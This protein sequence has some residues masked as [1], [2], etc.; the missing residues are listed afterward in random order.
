MKGTSV[1]IVGVGKTMQKHLLR[2]LL[3]EIDILSQDFAMSQAIFVIDS[4]SLDMQDMFREWA[5]KSPHN[6]TILTVVAPL[7]EKE[8]LFVNSGSALLPREGRIA[9]ARNIVLQEYQKGP[10]TEYIIQVDL[11]IVGWDLGGVRDSFGRSA[12]WDVACAHG[13]ILFGIYRD[14]YALRAPGINTNHHLSGLDHALYNISV[15]QK[16]Q[17][18]K[19]LVVS[20]RSS[21]VHSPYPSFTILLNA[22]NRFQSERYGN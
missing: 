3:I 1:T 20:H 16:V 9:H 18:R 21:I 7:L 17:N 4:L 2:N 22:Q 10:P 6:R 5:R 13:V 8:G 12:L 15:S 14:A 11:D 19:D